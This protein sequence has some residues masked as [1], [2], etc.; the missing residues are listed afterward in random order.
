MAFHTEKNQ[1]GQLRAK[2]VRDALVA[3]LSRPGD[4]NLS[5]KPETIAQR[6]ALSLVK[7]AV[8]GDTDARSEVIDRTD[9]KATQIVGGDADN[10]VMIGGIG[11]MADQK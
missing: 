6:L 2:P 9:G 11:W 3:I 4:D 1:N 10:P 7:D 8:N 5:D